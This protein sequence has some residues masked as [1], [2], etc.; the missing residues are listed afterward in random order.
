MIKLSEDNI[1]AYKRI[2]SLILALIMCIGV[3]PV[4]GGAAEVLDS[5]T[6]GDTLFW[7]LYDDGLLEIYGEGEMWDYEAVVEKIEGV[8]HH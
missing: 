2:T 6:C 7:R 1:S 8:T 5:G 3:F 4:L